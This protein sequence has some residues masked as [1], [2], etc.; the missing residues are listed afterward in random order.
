MALH[1]F[2]GDEVIATELP[3]LLNSNF[4]EVDEKVKPVSQGGTGAT[5][6]SQA[7]A[8]LGLGS[9]ATENIVPISKGGT[10]ADNASGACANIGALP[11]SG[12][13]MSDKIVFSKT[14]NI[15][16]LDKTNSYLVICGG[17]AYNTGGSIVLNGK[18]DTDGRAGRARLVASDGTSES[19]IAVFP[20]GTTYAQTPSISD[21][22]TKIATTAYVKSNLSNIFYNS[23]AAHN[24][25]YRGKNLG[26]T[27]TTAQWTAIKNGTFDDLYLGDYWTI[28]GIQWVIMA[29]DYYL[30]CG[31]TATTAHH[32][33]IVPR[34]VLYSAQM[35]TSNTTDGGYVGSAMYTTNLADAKT[36]I[37]NAFGSAHILTIRQLFVNTVA[38]G[39]S[40][41]GTWTDA[42][43]W[44]MN[45]INVYGGKIFGDC[46]QGTKWAYLYTIDNA[47][48]PAFMFNP[49][50][51][52]TRQ[53]YWLRDVAYSTGFAHVYDF[54]YCNE[55]YASYSLGVR[56]AFCIYQS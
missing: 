7:R 5:T 56:P 20:D 19:Y 4:K 10:G 28:N 3:S 42:T 46:I 9:V 51:I 13:T 12:G 30:N 52:K 35:N 18:D 44:L 29:F 33:V 23:A 43:V 50:L 45:E 38:N 24:C 55:S 27:V 32:I 14:D 49:S 37:A 26:S 34:T 39:Y 2:T 22:S 25:I 16:T 41:N 21:N 40:S 1:N 48:Y 8:N 53:T 47:Q 17:T 54:G 31:D 11:T 36:T 6:A 15:I